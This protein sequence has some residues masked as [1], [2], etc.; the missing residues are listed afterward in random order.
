MWLSAH[1]MNRHWST[2]DVPA[3]QQFAYWRE[4]VCEAVMNVATEDAAEDDFSGKIACADYGGLRFATFTSTAHRIVRQP[5]HIA[6]S[7]SAHFLISLQRSGIGRMQQANQSCELWAGDIGIVDG[8]RPFSVLFPQTVDRAV[9]V[10]PSAMLHGRAPWL[11]DCPIGRMR[12]DPE[13]HPMLRMT[14][15]RLAG[16]ACQ[17]TD[18]AELLADNLCNLV[19]LLTAH[20]V[21]DR[22]AAQARLSDIERMLAFIRRHLNDPDLSPQTLAKY[23]NVS[24]RTVHNRFEAAETSFGRAV[25]DLRLDEARRALCDPRHAPHSVTQIAYSLGFNDLSHFS[26]TFRAKFGIPPGQ[27]RTR[28]MSGT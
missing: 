13:L 22:N 23:L 18:E 9:A 7:N 28:R 8:A 4:A 6:R 5:S 24:V 1:E 2:T 16:P 21:S 27:Y 19:A 12:H 10:I 15:E 17:S 20:N 14:I 25:L 3:R 11:R 26:K